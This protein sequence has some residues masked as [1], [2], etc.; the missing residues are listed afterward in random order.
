MKNVAPRYQQ[1]T[2][3]TSEQKN[4]FAQILSPNENDEGVWIHQDAWFHLADFDNGFA[5]SYTI[6]KEGNGMYVFVISGGI[7]V[8][9]QALETRDG[10]GVTDFETLEI[11][12]TTDSK[13]L[14]MEVP[15]NQ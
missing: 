1:I 5:K 8:D 2:L 9:G 14:L 4:N 7:S 15:M 6:K 12:A 11:K 3:D 10:L 13:F